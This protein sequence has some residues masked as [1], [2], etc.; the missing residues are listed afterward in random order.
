M[1][2]AYVRINGKTSGWELTIVLGESQRINVRVGL[3][4]YRAPN[5]DQ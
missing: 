4:Y 2:T 5:D 1:L 3:L